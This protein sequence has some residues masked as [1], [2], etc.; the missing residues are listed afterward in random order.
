MESPKVEEILKEEMVSVVKG[1]EN[2]GTLSFVVLLDVFV[3]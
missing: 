3:G 2:G 1:D